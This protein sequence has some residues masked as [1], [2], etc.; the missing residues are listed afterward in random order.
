MN[1][2]TSGAQ[3]YFDNVPKAWDALYAPENRLAY[4]INKWLRKG[5]YERYRLTF[6]HC[7]DLTGATVLDIGCGTGRYSI[8]C[9]K[10]GAKRVVGIDFAPSM[11]DYSR[12]VAKELNLS[13]R[14]KFICGDFTRHAFDETFNIALALGF[15]DYVQ[16]AE[17]VFRKVAALVPRLFIASFPAPDFLWDIQRKIRYGWI[18][19]CTIYNYTREQLEGLYR[20]ASFPRFEILDVGTGFVG[21]AG[22][23]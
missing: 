23:R 9:G 6:K 10:R 11:I 21:I 4:L 3:R 20:A 2:E 16:D 5:L 12:Q 18:K 15:F 19:K 7:G 17:P 8:E 14:C 1:S 13:G 22:T